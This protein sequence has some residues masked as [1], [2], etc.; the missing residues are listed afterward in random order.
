MK[1]I[2]IIKSQARIVTNAGLAFVGQ[3]LD[4]AGFHDKCNSLPVSQ[5]HPKTRSSCAVM[6]PHKPMF[7]LYLLLIFHL[8][9]KKKQEIER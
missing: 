2:E 4:K 3:L 5:A 1:S 6:L 8:F 7:I 9:S